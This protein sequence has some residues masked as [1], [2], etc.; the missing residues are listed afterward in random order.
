MRLSRRHFLQATAAAGLFT[1]TPRLFANSSGKADLVIKGGTF[2]TMDAAFVAPEALAVANGRILAVGSVAEIDALI[3]PGT[4]VIDGRTLTIT[5]GFIDAHSHP[6]FANEAV[7]ANVGVRTIPG[8]LEA[9]AERKK[10]TPPGHWVL[11]VMYDDTKFEEGRPVTRADLDKLGDEHPIFIQH[12][13]GHTAVVNSAAFALAGIDASTPDPQGGKYYREGGELTGRIAE[14]ALKIFHTVGTWPEVT[15]ETRQENARLITK[16]MAASGLTSTTDAFGSLTEWETYGDAHAAGEL[17]CRISFMPGGVALPGEDAPAY[18]VLREQGLK[19]GDG[20]EMLR[21]GAVKYAV[22][23]SASE[24]TM[25]MST[26]YKGRPEDFGILMMNAE[27]VQAATDDALAHGWRIGIHANGDVAID[28]VLTAYE[29]AL[30]GWQGPNPRL[31]IEH[32][33]LV[34]PELIKRIKA[35]GTIPAPF[36]TYAHYHGEKWHEYGDEKME[37]MFAHKAFL[38]AGVPVAPASDYTPGPYEPM[39]ALQSMVT[40]KDPSGHVWGASQRVSV[41]EAMQICTVNGAYASIE[42]D[43]KGSLTPGKLAD[44]VLLERDPA[45]ADPDAL[46]DIKVVETI[47]GG[48]TTHQA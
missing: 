33:S 17:S 28:M 5:P 40:R 22:D 42:E 25:R 39:M 35:T 8:V 10:L 2:H 29:K 23:G 37:W 14:T 45:K 46:K 13:G 26:P 4:R 47:M 20:D 15:R 3:G 27:E 6:L 38:D 41:M 34:N 48:K 19:S 16:R 44:I 43:I 7:S 18:H 32:C 11:G 21:L 30:K 24:R 1:A 9:L 12:R 31:R 36:Y